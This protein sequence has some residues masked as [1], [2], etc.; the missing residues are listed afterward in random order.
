MSKS[1]IKESLSVRF[2]TFAVILTELFVIGFSIHTYYVYRESQS[3]RKHDLR[4][5]E[6]RGLIMQLDEVLTMSARMAAATG[7]LD[8]EQRYRKFEPELDAAIKEVIQ[9]SPGSYSG[10][11]AKETDDANL[12]LVRLEH[13]SFEEVRNGRSEEAKRILFSEE[14]ERYKKIYAGGM[15]RFAGRLK[16]GLEKTARKDSQR[17]TVYILLA[18]VVAPMLLIGWLF[19]L[20]AIWEWEKR[21][22]DMNRELHEKTRELNELNKTLDERIQ[23]QI[24]KRIQEEERFRFV[25]ES[26]PYGMMTVNQ[27][28]RMV[29]INAE[30]ERMFG[31]KREELYDK[32]IELLVPEKHRSKHVTDREHYTLAPTARTMGRGLNL[33]G[34]H[35]D[36]HEFPVD[37]SLNPIETSEGVIILASV[38]DLTGRK[39]LEAQML[40]SEKMA[41]IGQ[42]AGGVA[43]EINNP[44]GV[45]LGFSQNIA[46]RIKPGDPL[47]M[48]VKSIERE[49]IRCK[50]LVRD[51]LTFSRIGKTEKESVDLKEAVEGALSLVLAQSKVKN[52]DLLKDFREVPR[53][54]ANRNQIQQIIVNLSN[55]AMDAMP[56]GGK[57]TVRLHKAKM[58]EQEGVEILVQDTGQGIPR[59]IQ[60]KIFNPFFTTKEIGKGTGLGLSLVYEIVGKHNGKIFVDSEVGKGTIFHI[61]LPASSEK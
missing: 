32:E 56:K 4:L 41:A 16:E 48:P 49:A 44:L 2:L 60:S 10:E 11:A 30:L 31:Y 3:S 25:V 9:L 58:E 38:M 43:H 35:K 22:L 18:T 50:N 27:K 46:K 21:L 13:R 55:N 1:S 51:L 8:W 6:L 7:N 33:M 52:V 53:I 17:I 54:L 59:E 37:I 42:L 28:G 12:K 34:R 19:V 23:Q 26:S 15:S 14:Y 57:I 47:E 29:L 5:T 40:Q 36:G 61:L 24:R 39:R 20:K 45:I